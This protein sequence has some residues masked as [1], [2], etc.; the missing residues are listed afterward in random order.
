MSARAEHRTRQDPATRELAQHHRELIEA[1]AITADVAGE[2]GYFTAARRP[3]LQVLGF[4]PAQRNVPALVIPI[5]DAAGEVVNYQIR[6]DTPRIAESGKPLKYESPAGIR[7]TLD[8]P[9][10]CREGLR[11]VHTPL[12]ITE[13]ARKAD[14]AASAGLC[15]VSLPGVWSWARR[16]NGD[17]RQVL[18]DL[19]RL[20][21]EDRKVVI[22]FDSD[23]MAKRQVHAALEALSQ[24][25]HSQGALVYFAYLPEPEPGVKCGLDDFLAGHDVSEAWE[26]VAEELRQ[27]PEPRDRKRRP[28][29]PTATLLAYVDNILR[30][31]VHFPNGGEHA[32]LALSLFVLHTHAAEATMVT[33]YVYV[34]SPQKRSGKT[35]LLEVLELV[36]S[37]PI[38]AASITEAAL[39][40]SIE[41]FSPTLLIDEVDAIFNSRSERAEA[42]RGVLNA[43]NRRGSYV[44]RGTQDGT[45]ARSDTF[46][47]KVLA[48]IDT[49]KLPDTIRDRALVIDLERKMRSEPVERLRVA[50]LG[51]E[52]AE[53]RERLTDWAAE[54]HDELAA[55][56]CEPITEISDRLE[57]GWEPLLAI[58]SLAGED[59]LAAARAAAVALGA[60]DDAG[61]DHGQILLVALRAIFDAAHKVGEDAALTADIC[62]TLN[63]DDELPFGG[64]RRGEGIEGR[65]L[66]S[67]L[68]PHGIRPKNVRV[69]GEQ[70]KGYEVAQFT[71]A[72]ERYAPHDDPAGEASQASHRPTEAANGNGKPN[73]SGTDTQ[74][75]AVPG[76]AYPSQEAA[77]T[78]TAEPENASVPKPYHPQTALQSGNGGVRDGGTDGTDDMQGVAREGA[79]EL[80][81]G[82]P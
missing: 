43:G 70:G 72:W 78:D 53:L 11:S 29:Q 27:L 19:Q 54:H 6:P 42:I 79:P 22:A 30:R 80:T 76:S 13:G 24:Y 48:G 18:P 69:A 65:R 58:A 55:F 67:L 31:F 5:R 75:L 12:W 49:G 82:A 64:Y 40:Q 73:S 25:L 8:V 37:A 16:L 35:R 36:C 77:G 17:A 63:R 50:D 2:R 7:P 68:R 46:C 74:P 38:R 61:E 41:A 4:A 39:F 56:R 62:S 14:S 9:L 23:V 51:D 26:Y 1:S 52:P 45:P 81:G 66:A 3:E 32:R 60:T 47:P 15:C 59:T 34:K 33:P 10:R 71:E 44:I 21:L 20:R 28:A 57:E